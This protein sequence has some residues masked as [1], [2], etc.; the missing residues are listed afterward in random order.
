MNARRATTELK[1]DQKT[2][3]ISLKA[4]RY[5]ITRSESHPWRGVLFDQYARSRDRQVQARPLKSS[6][7]VSQRA[8]REVRHLPSSR[9]PGESNRLHL[10]SGEHDH[11]FSILFLF[12]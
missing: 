6:H 7:C 10:G 3:K 1:R 12:E 5:R 2:F 4:K 11:V 8:S 9:D